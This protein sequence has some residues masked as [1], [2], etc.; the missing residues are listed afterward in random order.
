MFSED[1]GNDGGERP[2]VEHGL[3]NACGSQTS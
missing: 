2:R 3:L 1:D